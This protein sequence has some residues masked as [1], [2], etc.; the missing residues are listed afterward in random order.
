M[1]NFERT[2]RAGGLISVL[3]WSLACP[4]SSDAQARAQPKFI[5]D[6]MEI[7]GAP[8]LPEAAREQVISLVKQQQ[9]QGT[10]VECLSKLERAVLEA[11]RD[12]QYEDYWVASVGATWRL[13]RRDPSGDLH[14]S[15]TAELGERPAK[16]R[17]TS[18]RFVNNTLFPS[19][20]LRNMVPLRDEGI[21][22]I[23]DQNELHRGLEAIRKLYGS[24]GYIDATISSGS[25]I[26][27]EHRTISF[28]FD[29]TEG[30]QY[31]I[32]SVQIVALDPT[33]QDALDS[34]LKPGDVVNSEL[35]SAFFVTNKS[36]LPANAWPKD[37]KIARH[38]KDGTVDLLFDFR[39]LPKDTPDVG[40]RSNTR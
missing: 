21:V 20:E 40:Q 9:F 38:P 7:S 33:L 19:D 16:Y 11:L 25:E 35:I 17:L 14:V 26:D 30:R 1:F 32:G 37:V 23:F 24:H 34:K 6:D 13:I 8:H 5:I 36:V 28:V 22:D 12:Q 2:M 39:T 15:V 29:V 31:R 10:P 27:D 3:L 4:F 18:I